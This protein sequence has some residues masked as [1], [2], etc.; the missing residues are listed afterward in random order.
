MGPGLVVPQVS[1]DRATREEHAQ[2]GGLDEHALCRVQNLHFFP[3]VCVSKWSS[4][5]LGV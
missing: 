1:P 4:S 5:S 3:V 2:R